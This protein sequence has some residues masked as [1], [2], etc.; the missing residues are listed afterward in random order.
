MFNKAFHDLVTKSRAWYKTIKKVYCPCLGAD[1]IFNAKGFY[2]LLY[3]GTGTA[4]SLNERLRRLKLLP[5]VIIV[6]RDAKRI[7]AHQA[8]SSGDYWLLKETIIMEE[9]TLNIIVVLRKTA[10]GNFFYYSVRDE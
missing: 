2:H 3:D 5:H 8:Q 6:I 10:G 1:V 4:R 9:A 7:Y